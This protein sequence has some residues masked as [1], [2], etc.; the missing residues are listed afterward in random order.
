MRDAGR[1][2]AEILDRVAPLVVPGVAP[3]SSTPR[4]TT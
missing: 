3:S 1:L 2:V 4:C